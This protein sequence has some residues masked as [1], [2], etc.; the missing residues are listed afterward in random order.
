MYHM[1]EIQVW[2]PRFFC[3]NFDL[4]YFFFKTCYG[5]FLKFT[6]EDSIKI[7]FSVHVFGCGGVMCSPGYLQAV[8]DLEL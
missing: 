8:D 2:I 1:H 3:A 4:L 6:M 5:R 7:H